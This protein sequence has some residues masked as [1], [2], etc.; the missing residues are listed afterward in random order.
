MLVPPKPPF[1]VPSWYYK[2]KKCTRDWYKCTGD[3]Y[4]AVCKMEITLMDIVCWPA[5]KNLQ[6]AYFCKILFT[7]ALEK[8]K[9]SLTTIPLIDKKNTFNRQ[10]QVYWKG[11]TISTV[12]HSINCQ[13]PNNNL[14][15][16]I[17][18]QFISL[19]WS[20]FFHNDIFTALISHFPIIT[21]RMAPHLV[22]T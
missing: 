11:V 13:L 18:S 12:Y 1:S 19:N 15:N 17:L 5:P 8:C 7:L 20:T 3:R 10:K 21:C 14:H 6:S 16:R 22:Q 2:W 9:G 4:I